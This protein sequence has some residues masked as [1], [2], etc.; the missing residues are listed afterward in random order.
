MYTNVHLVQGL[1]SQEGER[2]WRQRQWQE[3]W[4]MAQDN[5]KQAANTDQL[6]RVLTGTVQYIVTSK[7]CH[8]ALQVPLVSAQSWSLSKH[9][10]K[11]RVIFVSALYKSA[12][13]NRNRRQDLV[14]CSRKQRQGKDKVEKTL[15]T[16]SSIASLK[17]ANW[18]LHGG[19]PS[20][21]VDLYIWLLTS[22]GE[23]A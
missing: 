7:N 14:Q 1:V 20:K 9:H 19:F 13:S 18:K 8:K 15:T 5:R 17:K 2:G 21:P 6:D 3:L 12:I 22:A 11:D 16:W 23:P 10:T 4:G